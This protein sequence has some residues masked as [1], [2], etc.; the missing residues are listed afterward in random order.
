VTAHHFGDR[1][2]E[3]IAAKQSHVVVGFDPDYDLLPPEVRDAHPRESYLNEREMKADCYRHFLMAVLGCV[4]DLAVAI[5]M[6]SACFEALGP[7]GY[8]LY[9][10][11]VQPIRQAGL[12]VVGD[13]KRGDIGSTA[14]VY[15]IAHLDIADV[16][17]ATVNPYLGADSMEPFLARA[18]KG[19]KGVFVLVKTSNPGSADIQDLELASGRLVYSRVAEL[20]KEW[21]E[22][23]E[24]ASGYRSVGAVVGGTHPREGA[25][26]RA[27]MPGVPLLVPGY[28]AQ[29]ATAADLRGLFDTAGSGTVVNSSRAVLYA[30]RNHLGMSWQDA[31]RQEAADMRAALWEAAKRG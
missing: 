31:A 15:A 27:Q 24:G 19:G 6:Q 9:L 21:G 14:E 22:G 10:E 18:Q 29:G 12:L 4:S 5:K 25:V 28:G 11:L 3:A 8:E 7:A 30:Y 20:V 1:L 26:L 23:T 2:L 16:D 13:V 17:A